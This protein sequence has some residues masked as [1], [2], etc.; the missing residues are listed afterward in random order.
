MWQFIRKY[1]AFTKAGLHGERFTT[2]P[3]N[4]TGKHSYKYSGMARQRVLVALY[5]FT[6]HRRQVL[7]ASRSTCRQV[8]ATRWC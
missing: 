3:G 2:E 7:W 8:R 1:T 4:L 5:I 6:L